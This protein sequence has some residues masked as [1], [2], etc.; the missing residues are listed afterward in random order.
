MKEIENIELAYEILPEDYSQYDLSFKIILIGDSNV[1]KNDLVIK[2][3]KK[4]KFEN[5]YLATV[6]FEYFPFNMKIG[7]KV[8]KLQIWDF[9]Y[10]YGQEI[11]FC[12]TLRTSFYN[13]T[14]LAIIIYAINE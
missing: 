5:N 14:Y 1:G 6:G 3:T 12:R 11:Y 9:D 2:A 7:N 10:S 4:K 8:I 13:N